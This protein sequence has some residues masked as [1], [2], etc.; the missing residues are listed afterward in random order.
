MPVVARG[1]ARVSDGSSSCRRLAL[2]GAAVARQLHCASVRIV[3]ADLRVLVIRQ[4]AGL[5]IVGLITCDVHA[6]SFRKRQT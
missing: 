5:Q 3:R 2:L 4:M 1:R 6:T